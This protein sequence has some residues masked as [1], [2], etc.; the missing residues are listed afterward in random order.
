LFDQKYEKENKSG[1]ERL[2]WL[3]PIIETDKMINNE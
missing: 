2:L 3:K 1:A